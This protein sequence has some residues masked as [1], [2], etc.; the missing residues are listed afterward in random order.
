MPEI[1]RGGEG[2]GPPQQPRNPGREKTP[3]KPVKP[4]ERLLTA[5]AQELAHRLGEVPAPL[6]SDQVAEASTRWPEGAPPLVG[7]ELR[8]VD[9]LARQVVETVLQLSGQELDPRAL[10]A[11]VERAARKHLMARPGQE[12]LLMARLASEIPRLLNLRRLAQLA[13]EGLTVSPAAAMEAEGGQEIV[14]GSSQ[15]FRSTLANLEQVAE[16]DFPVLLVG[17]TGTGKELM[18]R[19]LHQLSP[20]RGGPFVPLNCAAVPRDL[21]E[22]ELFG[23]V[24][25]AFTGAAGESSGYVRAAQGGTLFLDEIGETSPEFQ[26]RLLRVLETREVT[27]LGS[28][29]SQRVDFR[30]VTASHRDLEAAAKQGEF[31][32]PLLYRILV[33]PIHLP[34]LRARREDLPALVDHF[35]TQ[36]CLL[37]RRTRRLAPETLRLLL[38]YH[39]PGNVRQ[40]SHTLQRVVALSRDFVIT[41]DLLPGEVRASAQ[42]PGRETQLLR[43]AQVAGVAARHHQALAALLARQPGQELYNRDLRESLGCSDSTAKNILRALARDGI[44]ESV[45]RRGGRRYVVKDTARE[46]DPGGAEPKK[47]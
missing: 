14:L 36:A 30:L 12:R 33:V 9:D 19:R 40:L 46:F 35:L 11:A 5:A 2:P 31:H 1:K 3:E 10:N 13:G 27:P 42:G 21:L 20:R 17:E 41:P 28:S 24:K 25:G 29:V 22:N 15:A 45:G 47:E 38:D 23:H 26:V 6:V 7:A 32:R 34:P 44:L 39:W 18:A 43:L 8:S 16:T 37:A 4:Q